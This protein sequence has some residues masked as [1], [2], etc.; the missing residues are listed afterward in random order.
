ML[1]LLLAST[2]I[3]S[4]EISPNVLQL[5]YLTPTNQIVTI[6][7]NVEIQGGIEDRD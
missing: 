5:E 7:E 6:L 4:R 1:E 2:I 3:G